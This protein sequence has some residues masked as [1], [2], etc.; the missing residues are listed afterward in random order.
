MQALLY[1]AFDELVISEEPKPEAAAEEVVLAVAACGICGSELEGFR[2]H[3]PRRQPPKIM[4]HEF[5]GQIIELGAGVSNFEIGENVVCNALVSCGSCVRCLGGRP[6]LC[7]T[8]QIFGMHRQ[9]AFADYVNVPVASL[10]PWPSELSAQAACL[11]EP[12]GNGVH[13]VRLTAHQQIQSALVLGAGPIGLMCQQTLQTLR[14]AVVFV[15]DLLPDRLKLAR[16]LG[17]VA[18]IQADED[19]V[20]EVV[21]ELTSGEGVDVVVD[22]V[23]SAQTKAL[24]IE[25]TRPGGSAVWIGLH[26][27]AMS[28]NSYAL[29][30]PEK[31]VLGSYAATLSD[32]QEALRLMCEGLVE[33]ESWTSTYPLDQGVDIFR[34]MLDPGA[35]DVKAVLAPSSFQ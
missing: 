12:L 17:A 10:L 30:L 33:V 20:S 11:A 35:G 4:G 19:N 2:N 8:R 1:S 32:L 26:G 3:S 9:G 13:V 6:H 22:A 5:C 24:S 28:L 16:Q 29:T 25:C 7:E 23:G 18:T 21:R 14:Q 34:R 27:D 31:A 15:S